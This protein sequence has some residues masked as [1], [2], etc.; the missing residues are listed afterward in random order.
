MSGTEFEGHEALVSELRATPP[1]AP[2]RLRERV[3]ALGPGA[4]ASADG[5]RGRKKQIEQRARGV[6]AARR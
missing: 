5:A 3:L 6:T 1:F 2:E 4:C